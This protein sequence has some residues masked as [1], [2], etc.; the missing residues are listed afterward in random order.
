MIKKKKLKE[1]FKEKLDFPVGLGKDESC[2]E[3]MGKRRVMV[4]GC[5]GIIEYGESLMSLK[6]KEGRVDITGEGL[7]CTAYM[8]GAVEISGDIASVS[9]GEAV[10]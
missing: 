8:A 3:V 5:A 10:R 4:Y 1:L 6:I 7:Y 2:V 9:Y